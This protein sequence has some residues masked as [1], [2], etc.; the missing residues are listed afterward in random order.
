MPRAELTFSLAWIELVDF[1]IELT[2][3]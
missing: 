2:I 3:I 1:Q